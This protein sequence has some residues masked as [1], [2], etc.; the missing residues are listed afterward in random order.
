MEEKIALHIKRLCECG[1]IYEDGTYS[2]TQIHI[3]FAS[4]IDEG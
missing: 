1:H 2:E 3:T 4:D